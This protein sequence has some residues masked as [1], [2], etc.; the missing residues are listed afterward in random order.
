[1]RLGAILALVGATLA[2]PAPAD[3]R[4]DRATAYLVALRD[5]QDVAPELGSTSNYSTPKCRRKS[6]RRIDCR[7]WAEGTQ[8]EVDLDGSYYLHKRCRWVV[9]TRETRFYPYARSFRRKVR[10]RNWV[11]D[12]PLG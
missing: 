8:F 9:V 12:S 6:P 7:V 11:T 5:A 1:M 2:L 3:A 4:L 10:C